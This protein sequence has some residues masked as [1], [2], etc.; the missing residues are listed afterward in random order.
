[1]SEAAP[2]EYLVD[3]GSGD[4][5]DH[6]RRVPKR[7]A[8]QDVI[9]CHTSD[10]AVFADDLSDVVIGADLRSVGAR[11]ERVLEGEPFRVLDLRIVIERCATQSGLGQPRR[12]GESRGAIE[13]LMTRQR[14]A[15]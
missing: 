7:L 10:A 9:P 12:P 1:M 6:R 13:H 2:G 4:V 11:I 8:G 5:D 3:P 15:T 14:F